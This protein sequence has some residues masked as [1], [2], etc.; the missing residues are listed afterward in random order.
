MIDKII[1]TTCRRWSVTYEEILSR[2]RKRE[3]CFARMTIGRFLRKYTALSLAE[4]GKLINRDHSTIIYYLNSFDVE[5]RYNDTFRN[6]VKNIESE[7]IY[8]EL[9]SPLVIEL[10]DEYNE[11]IDSYGV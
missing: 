5:Y 9:K 2:C 11:I 10:E 8:N 1:Q 4:I 3:L 6:F 7:I